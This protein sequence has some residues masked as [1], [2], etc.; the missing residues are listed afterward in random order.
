MLGGHHLE[1]DRCFEVIV[2]AL[3]GAGF[4]ELQVTSP[5][6]KRTW[7]FSDVLTLTAPHQLGHLVEGELLT[8]WIIVA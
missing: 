6:F 4:V 7:Q 5:L 2:N 8:H 3:P 1:E